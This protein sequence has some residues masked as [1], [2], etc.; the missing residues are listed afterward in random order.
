MSFAD[1]VK[2]SQTPTPATPP[3]AAPP[4]PAAVMDATIAEFNQP[5]VPPVA[6]P[7]PLAPGVAP[8]DKDAIPAPVVEAKKTRIRIGTKE[9][10]SHDAALE[11]AQALELQSA[12]NEGY[13]KAVNELKPKEPPTPVRTDVDDI[14]DI[15]FEDPKQALTKIEQLIEK[16]VNEKADA[17]IQEQAKKAELNAHWTNFWQ[18][19]PELQ[20][21][22]DFVGYVFQKHYEELGPL[23]ADKAFQRLGE[24]ARREA[25][26]E[27][28]A[29][30]AE[31]P[32]PPGPAI[33]APTSNTA[34][35]APAQIISE[36]PVDFVSQVNNIRKRVKR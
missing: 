30:R 3:P 2:H 1:E 24:I 23:P 12:E 25:R 29:T 4:A 9:F 27:R 8:I 33:V 28:E 34:T 36:G 32:M 10:D 18:A 11:Y 26:I 6:A 31:T 7:Q 14:S 16:R 13:I 19:N 17:V 22:S 35:P 15:L 20:E 21:R 5:A